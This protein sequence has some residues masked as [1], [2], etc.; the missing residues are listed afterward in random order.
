MYLTGLPDIFKPKNPNFGVSCNGRYLY[1]L[2]PLGLFY[3]H[4]VYFTAIWSILLP[5]CLFYCHFVYFTAILS[6]LRPFGLFYGH[7]VFFVAIWSTLWPFG[8]FSQFWYV[9]P[10][11]IWQPWYLI[12]TNDFNCVRRQRRVSLQALSASR[13]PIRRQSEIGEPPKLLLFHTASRG[14]ML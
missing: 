8:I 4:L 14:P 6:I 2:W 9:A 13:L 11:K 1:I 5:F 10:G 3:D 7:L 12:E